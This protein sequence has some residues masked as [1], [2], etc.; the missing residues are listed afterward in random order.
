MTFLIISRRRTYKGNTCLFKK[1]KNIMHT[2]KYN[3]ANFTNTYCNIQNN[4]LKKSKSMI[5][6]VFILYLQRIL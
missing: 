3:R 4:F 1:N 6:N 2:K 5:H